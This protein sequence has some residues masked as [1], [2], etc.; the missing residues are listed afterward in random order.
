MAGARQF[1]ADSSLLLRAA[2]QAG[3]QAVTT[4]LEPTQSM[5]TVL[6][7]LTLLLTTAAYAAPPAIDEAAL[8]RDTQVLSSD[9]FEGR[10]P[11]TPGGDKAVAYMIERFKAV[12]LKPGNHG[13]WTQ[14]VPMVSSTA[15][16][17]LT[18][19]VSGAATPLTFRQKDDVVLWTKRQVDRAVVANSDIV[20][21]GYGIVAPERGWNDYAGF[22]VRGK[23]V[24]VLVNDP[25]WQTPTETGRFDGRRMTY[26]GRWTYKYEEAA[27]QGAAAIIIVHETEPAAYPFEVVVNSNTGT[28]ID[29]DIPAEA[30]KRAMVEGWM[31]QGAA[32]QLFAAAGKDLGALTKA[33]QTVGFRAVP[34]GLKASTSFANTLVHSKSYNVV[35]ILPGAKRPDEMVI[36]TA[37]WDHFGRCPADA[38]GDDICNG[39]LDNASGSA[40]L[41]AVADALA[42]AP[43]TARSQ[44]FVSVTG[45]EQGLLG[46]DYY[47]SNPVYPLA[48]T[49]G[50]INMDGLNVLGKTR[51][52]VL[53]GAGKSELEP[54]FIG[55]VKA[56]GRHISPE[57]SVEKGMF[58]RSDHFSLAKRG[59]PMLDVDSG[60]DVIG[61]PAGYGQRMADDYTANRYH[62]PS[63]QYDAN[64]N[65]SGAV[66]DLQAYVEVATVLG[67]SSDWPNWYKTAEFRAARDASRGASNAG[68]GQP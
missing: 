18:L 68:G 15:D 4:S 60:L 2:V 32:Q 30:A 9:A 43:R 23:T 34:L 56:Q 39:A 59:V 37:H 47:A 19:T 5:K 45:E 22:D 31:T 16:P 49:V 52:V 33:A 10:K 61:K 28:K 29:L 7:T 63:D 25:D 65:W 3:S 24:I 48:K 58:Y 20:F 55:I 53:I 54:I 41:I 44:L 64:W 17:A 36:W 35:G 13:G 8:K 6:I 12:G 66:E 40:G 46:S 1:S 21:A 26:Y 27:R 67:N 14:D 51:D 38:T 57:P 42:K 11:G 62:K 50:G